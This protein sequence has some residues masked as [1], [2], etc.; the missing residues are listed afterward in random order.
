MNVKFTE[1]VVEDATF[2]WLE[3]LDYT[4]GHAPGE[5]QAERGR[6]DDVVLVGR[7]RR[8]LSAINTHIPAA[9]RG[10]VIDDVIKAVL[11]LD[12]LDV[13]RSNRQ[14]HKWLVEGFDVNYRD[15]SRSVDDKVWLMDFDDPDNNDWLALNQFTVTH[16]NAK[17][18]AKTDRRP[19]V[20]LFVNGLPLVVIELKNAADEEA[21]IQN[22]FH[23]I[24]TYKEDIRNLFIY[25]EGI[26]ISDGVMA[27]FGTLTAG[28]EWFK[29]WRTIDGVETES[30]SLEVLLKG[31][32]ERNTYLDLVKSFTVFEDDGVNVIKKVA[33]YHQYHAVNKAIAETVRASSDDGD[34]RIGVIWHTQGSGKSLSMLFYA[35]KVI[36]HEAMN[37]PTIIVLTDRN[38]LDDQLFGTFAGGQELL[39]QEPKQ[40]TDRDNLKALLTVASGGVV[41]TTI[42]KFHPDE[43]AAYPMLS[44]RRNIVFIADE[45]H[46]SQYG[47]DAKLRKRDDDLVKA[48]GFAKYVRDALSNASFIGFTGTP[49]ELIGANTQQV[50]G[51]YIDIYDIQDA[52]DD[53]ATVP[54]YYQPRIVN[55]E[56]VGDQVPQIDS[57]FDEITEDE[58]DTER[59]RLRTKWTALEALV[60]ADDRLS[61][62][63]QDIVNHYEERTDALEGKA[64]IVC[65]SRRICVDLYNKIINLRPEWHHNTDEQ[66]MVKVIMTGSASDPENFQ[67]H[68]RSKP[69]RKALAKRFKDSNDPFKI[70]IVRDMWLT[71]FDAP[72]LHT[73][74]TDKPMRGHSLMQAIARVNRV[75]KDKPG[76]LI[77][78]YLGIATELQNAIHQYTIKGSQK[79]AEVVD[80]AVKLMKTH[81][82]VVKRFYHQFDYHDFFSTEPTRRVA[83][84]PRAMEHI[85]SQNNGKKR[86]IEAVTQLSKSYALSMPD[87]NALAI[88]D[89]V[90]F[91]QAVK[92]VFVKNT[93]TSGKLR[94]EV[95]SAIKQ[96]VSKSIASTDLV[97]IF[98]SQGLQ[99]PDLSVMSDDFLQSVQ[100]LPQ[101][102]LAIE[103]LQRLL[104]DEI[105]S[106]ARRNAVQA[107]SFS[108]LLEEAVKKYENRSVDAVV[109]INELINL[110]K[111]LRDANQRGEDLSLN[112]DELAFY[113]A[114]SEN[115]SAVQV[116]G[117]EKLAIIAR[118][119]LDSVRKNVT[120]DWTLR[121]SSRAKIRIL[122]KRILRKYGYPPDMEKVATETV[123]EQA[124]LIAATQQ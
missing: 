90:A 80:Q 66:G 6:Y 39:R 54:I 119:L 73:M 121:E 41:F 99:S 104:N 50:F 113:D 67:P 9:V 40:A 74:Y 21:D 27:R 8:A 79:P 84:I 81:Y 111:E 82:E 61:K 101:K 46:R 52:I 114:L 29:P 124:K 107:R 48:Y 42:Q 2:A 92:A 58:E 122:V 14:F 87:E 45:A 91:F 13:V 95:D 59:E 118:E 97:D 102:N 68:V 24:R 51:E 69:R 33:G 86:Y 16:V 43:A 28:W 108:K 94:D 44:D 105:K 116:M 35:G 30:E 117:D 77:V 103:L 65:M 89:D 32:F 7:L 3:D 12:T 20:I 115:D 25:N 64:M 47:F 19:D 112:D 120:I 88:R 4:I 49:I 100:K 123:L 98:R 36:Q 83:I 78:D 93:R 57:E 1:S 34:Q 17:S 15:G 37:N 10:T 18:Q 70:V 56:L 26:V 75:F 38:D 76:G 23:Q 96:L 11:G 60:G 106:R 63:A 53:G 85:L 5:P 31:I 110:A 62:V 72:P 109:I 22:A 55:L 71:G